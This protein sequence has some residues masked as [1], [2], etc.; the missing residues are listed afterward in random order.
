M[1]TPPTLFIEHGKLYFLH[2]YSS[3]TYMLPANADSCEGTS[4]SVLIELSGNS[5]AWSAKAQT[6]R[7][8]GRVRPELHYERVI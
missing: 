7:L 1:S 8:G 3:L 4:T 2:L 5:L 6:C